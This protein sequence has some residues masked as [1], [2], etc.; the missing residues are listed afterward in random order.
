MLKY[1]FQGGRATGLILCH[2]GQLRLLLRHLSPRLLLLWIL[3]HNHCHTCVPHRVVGAEPIKEGYGPA[4]LHV[5][6]REYSKLQFV[7]MQWWRHL[8]DKL[9]TELL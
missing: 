2:V 5:V 7:L 1:Y 6:M 9:L 3:R 8:V 4:W